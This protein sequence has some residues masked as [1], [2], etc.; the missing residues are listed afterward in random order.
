MAEGRVWQSPHLCRHIPVHDGGESSVVLPRGGSGQKYGQ[1]F[2]LE[3]AAVLRRICRFGNLE[4]I[5]LELGRF[6]DSM[7]GPDLAVLLP[8]L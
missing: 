2:T 4:R 5:L 7:A 6:A 8:S 3:Y 1:N